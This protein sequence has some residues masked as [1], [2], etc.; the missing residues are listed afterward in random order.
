[1][2]Y[3]SMNTWSIHRHLGPLRWTVWNEEEKRHDTHVDPQPETTTLLELPAVLAEKGFG[4][5]DVCHFHIPRTDAEYLVELREAFRSSGVAFHTL[6]LDYGDISS[7][8]ELRRASDMALAKEWIGIAAQAGAGHIRIIAG[9][10]QPDSAEA[11]E[12]AYESLAELAAWAEKHGVRI[13]T[14]NFRPLASTSANC[15]AIKSRLGDAIGLIGDFG[16]FV[17]EVRRE[18]LA[19]ILPFCGSV[20]AKPEFDVEGRPIEAEFRDLL[21]LLPDSGYDGP[22]TLIYDGPGDMWEGVERVRAIAKDYV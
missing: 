19:A 16:N 11:L 20:H 2:S 15:L 6:L 13:V 17:K 9:Q 10:A 21:Q 22:I 1:M 14:E 12:R 3:F 18:E 7:S 8:D 5:V 4:A